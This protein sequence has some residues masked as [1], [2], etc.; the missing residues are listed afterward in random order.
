MGSKKGASFQGPSLRVAHQPCNNRGPT[1][2]VCHLLKAPPPQQHY[3]KDEFLMLNLCENLQILGLM[4][5]LLVVSLA[6]NGWAISPAYSPDVLLES[7]FSVS[8]VRVEGRQS[9]FVFLSFLFVC[10]Y[11]FVWCMCVSACMHVCMCGCMC[12]L[13]CVYVNTRGWFQV[14]SSINLHC[15]FKLFIS[16]VC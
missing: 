9:T 12:L 11:V 14:L 8:D 2:L 13:A 7:R 1:S 3:A 10:V 6:P 16:R 15:G 5:S 4:S